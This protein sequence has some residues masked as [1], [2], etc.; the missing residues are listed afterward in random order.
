MQ[1]TLNH[2][3]A[4]TGFNEQDARIL[5]EVA[6]RTQKWV[7]MVVK[8]FYD[9]LYGYGPT[10]SVFK[11]GERPSVEKTLNDWY[12]MVTSGNYDD[13][14]WRHMWYVGLVHIRRKVA[15]IFMLTM[16]SRI[17]QIFLKQCLKEFDFAKA[18]KVYSAFKRVLD[19]V[20]GLISE[21]YT[22]GYI[23]SYIDSLESTLGFNK[24]LVKTMLDTE[25]EKK[26]AEVRAQL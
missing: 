20:A 17:Q 15:N 21:S 2:I 10:A 19:A 8:E 5:K 22:E 11:P 3:I 26:I 24:A 1:E 25:L 18:E 23:T 14:F 6:P 9:T 13:R 12:L 7:G 4:L 16:M